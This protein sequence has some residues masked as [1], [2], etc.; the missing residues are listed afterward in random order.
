M[1]RQYKERCG[2]KEHSIGY[3]CVAFRDEARVR[4]LLAE[5]MGVDCSS[6]AAA[7]KCNSSVDLNDQVDVPSACVSA[8]AACVVAPRRGLE[9]LLPA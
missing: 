6:P 4:E 9:P 7:D 2:L 8:I 1:F 5:E 3:E